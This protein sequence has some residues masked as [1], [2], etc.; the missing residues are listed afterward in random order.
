LLYVKLTKKSQFHEQS[1]KFKITKSI[2]INTRMSNPKPNK[3]SP[4]LG[5]FLTEPYWESAGELLDF[6]LQ[7]K[8][9]FKRSKPNRHFNTLSMFYYDR[10]QKNYTKEVK[11]EIF[12]NAKVANNLLYGLES[13]FATYSYPIP[14]ANN[15][16]LRQYHFYT[17]PMRLTYYSI[18]LYLLRL[19]QEF[20][21][22]YYDTIDRISSFYGGKLYFAE[23]GE[24]L[25][26]SYDNAWYQPH[27]SKFRKTV[28][29][30]V[31]KK[32]G[33]Q[34]VIRIDIQ[35]YFE[36]ISIPN[37]LKFISQYIKPSIQR[38]LR[39]DTVTQSQIIEFF[40]FL[41]GG[42]NGIPQ[43]DND[44]VSSYIGY[45]YL[46]FADMLIDQELNKTD[47]GLEAHSIIRYM[48][49]MYIFL[50]FPKLSN[51]ATREI[52]ISSIASRIADC[53]YTSLGL[54]LNTKTRLFW[55]DKQEDVDELLTNLRKVSSSGY[56]AS[57]SNDD[58]TEDNPHVKLDR[59]LEQ[60]RKLK[61]SSLDPT[62]NRRNDF[63]DEVLKEVYEPRVG[64]LLRSS[65]YQPQISSIFSG[66][67]F[68]L[69]IAQ[70]R[71]ILIVLL[72]DAAAKQKFKEFLLEKAQ[73][74]SYDIYLI[75]SFLCQTGFGSL[76]LLNLLETSDL[77]FP[78]VRKYEQRKTVVTHPGYFGLHNSQV[79][80]LNNATNVIEQIRL[81]VRAERRGDYSVA[82]NHLL[83]EIQSICYILHQPPNLQE[84]DY[85]AEQ[86]LSFLGKK[87]ILHEVSV[88]I[89]NLF[90][91][92]N[93][94]PV[95]HADSISW[96]VSREEYQDY[97]KHV[98]LCLN[99]IL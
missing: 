6:Q 62:F 64:Q 9:G 38:E 68:N 81:R 16:G 77:M 47:H 30:A 69:V 49:D 34:V 71:E 70:P 3:I 44:V 78:I 59:I 13:E 36:E 87:N 26:L 7:I 2:G 98:G 56:Y 11:S 63:D 92:R 83:N 41:S 74:T 35:N 24:K 1:K 75:L 57:T 39:F 72:A 10:L 53:L 84:K 50:T 21:R 20:V 28:R 51:R 61:R 88:K 91:R 32:S 29:D 54:R 66:F 15:L 94:N 93:K 97:H 46:V 27:Y 23:T 99:H 96:P 65:Q 52:C 5:Y 90:D 55:L 12:F 58:E 25:Q 8:R 80:K 82:L 43:M 48:D 37:L 33:N 4:Q 17:Y 14:K 22:N 60:L 76:K 18:G 42:Y 31:K 45:L 95:S 89:R 79:S 67:N 73:L 86:V 19:T 85:K 40:S